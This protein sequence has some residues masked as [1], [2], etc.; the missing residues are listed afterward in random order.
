MSYSERAYLK[1]VDSCHSQVLSTLTHLHLPGNLSPGQRY[2]YKQL[3]IM[4][5]HLRLDVG[6]GA[7]MWLQGEGI[8]RKVTNKVGRIISK[9]ENTIRDGDSTALYTASTVYTV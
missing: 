4:T 1:L 3:T 5:S 9:L 2:L 8:A 6:Q 7:A